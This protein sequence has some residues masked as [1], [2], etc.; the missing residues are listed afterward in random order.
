MALPAGLLEAVKNYLDISW[1][2]E[3]G[4]EKLSGII[5]RGMKYL[6]ET[7]GHALDYTKEEKPRELLFDYCRYVRSNALEK[8]QENYLSE[9][10]R[11]QQQYEIKYYAALKSLFIGALELVPAFDAGVFDYTAQTGNNTDIVTA[12]PEQATAEIIIQLNGAKIA[13]GGTASWAAGEN[14][15][16]IAVTYGN[17][18]RAYTVTVTKGGEGDG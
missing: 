4:D 9:L 3:A 7:A 18:M 8:F 17:I 11:L 12:E 6:D 5:A 10:L 2:D 14:T 15:L 13:N 1:T 16:T